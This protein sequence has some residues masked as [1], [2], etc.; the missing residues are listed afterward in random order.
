MLRSVEAKL[1]QC[2]DACFEEPFSSPSTFDQPRVISHGNQAADHG[3]QPRDSLKIGQNGLALCGFGFLLMNRWSSNLNFAVQ[4][5][6]YGFEFQI[7]LE[8]IQYWIVKA[9]TQIEEG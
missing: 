7:S 2:A 9:E 1:A 8:R 5:Q 4:V 6:L 3:S